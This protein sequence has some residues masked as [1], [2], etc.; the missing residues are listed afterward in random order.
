MSLIPERRAVVALLLTACSFN[1]GG[2]PGDS[3]ARPPNADASQADASTAADANDI[4]TGPG[5]PDANV[6]AMPD[7]MPDFD[8]ACV[9]DPLGF[10]PSNFTRCD[11]ATSNGAQM[12]A[13]PGTWTLSTDDGQLSSPT[14]DSTVTFA[15]V[16]QSGGPELMV[17]AFDNFDVPGTVTL[18]I[19]GARPLAIVSLADIGVSGTLSVGAVTTTSG[20]GGDVNALCGGNLGRGADGVVENNSNDDP[21]GTGGGGGGF[22]TVGGLGGPV[23]TNQPAGGPAGGN[24]TLVPLRGGCRGGTGGNTGGGLPGGAGGALQLVAV[25]DITISA[26]GRVTARGGG[27][28]GSTGASSAGG[29]GGAGGGLLFEAGS[30]VVVS[31]GGSVTANGGGGGEG[32]RSSGGDIF[33]ADG[34]DN[35]GTRAAG[36]SSLSTGGNGGGGGADEGDALPGLIGTHSATVCA[37]GGGGGGAEGRIHFRAVTGA[38]TRTGLISPDDL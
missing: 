11:I 17:V 35:S 26:G 5:D 14:S 1:E 33:G 15:L 36:G 2:L 29:G 24:T 16:P 6:D 37:G 12:F 3:D 13:I 28:R 32:S 10:Q 27:G 7:A 38:I 34:A 21:G 4:D 31:A 8:A 20:P 30:D 9:G 25:D 22:G 23:L 19:T 18:N